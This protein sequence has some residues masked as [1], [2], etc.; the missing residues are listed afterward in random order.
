MHEDSSLSGRYVLM[1][2]NFVVFQT[3]IRNDYKNL[4]A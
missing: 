4:E 1:Y 3:A 2:A